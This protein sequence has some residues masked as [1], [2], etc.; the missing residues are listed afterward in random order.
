MRRIAG[1]AA[2]AVITVTGFAPATALSP[3]RALASAARASASASVPGGT[4]LW[5][6]SYH[7]NAQRSQ[8]VAAAGSP[9]G[10]ARSTS[11]G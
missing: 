11:P 3:Q 1:L 6:A 7:G 10:I 9:D 5:A 4:Q 2:L 8:A